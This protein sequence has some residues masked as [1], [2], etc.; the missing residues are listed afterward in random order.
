MFN[1]ILLV[2]LG[3]AIGGVLRFFCYELFNFLAKKNLLILLKLPLATMLVNIVGSLIAGI[4][5]FF[6]IKNF[7]DFSPSLKNFLLTGFLGGF[8][9]F[10]A[11]SLDFFRLVQ[12]NQIFYAIIY[13]LSSV[14]LS[15]LAVFGGFY[16]LKSF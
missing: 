4:I 7:E 2:A 3:S 13:A 5:Y 10:S 15:L 6:I 1:N 16:L 14:A 12:A 11:F 8:T 9:T